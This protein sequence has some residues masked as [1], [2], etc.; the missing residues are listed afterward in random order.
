MQGPNGQ[1]NGPQMNMPMGAP[2]MMPGYQ[3]WATSPQQQG[4]GYGNSSAPNSYQGWG[5]PPQGPPPQWSNYNPQQTGWSFQIG[6]DL[7]FKINKCNRFM[8]Y[9]KRA[10]GI[11]I[12]FK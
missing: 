9:I 6:S 10:R 2:N 12:S 4:Y 7:F 3:N 1:M 5:A 8:K 11:H